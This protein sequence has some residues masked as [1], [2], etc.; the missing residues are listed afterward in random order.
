MHNIECFKEGYICDIANRLQK[1]Q[2][3][4]NIEGLERSYPKLLVEILKYLILNQGP[5]GI[6]NGNADGEIISGTE[7]KN[8]KNEFSRKSV[9]KFFCY[10]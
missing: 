10:Q 7:R 3:N 2:K 9:P 8:I 1:I 5:H 6:G 4:L